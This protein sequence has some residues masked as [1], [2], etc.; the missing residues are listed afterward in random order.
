MKLDCTQ[1]Y[2]ALS[3]S[4]GFFIKYNDPCEA[5]RQMGAA[6]GIPLVASCIY[7]LKHVVPG[8]E[9]VAAMRDRLIEFYGYTE[10]IE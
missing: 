9:Q 3:K 5:I 6:A 4:T 1:Y 2:S 10:V 7:S 8:N